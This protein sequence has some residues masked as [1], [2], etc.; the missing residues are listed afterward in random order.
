MKTDAM[1]DWP[2]PNGPTQAPKTSPHRGL[3]WALSLSVAVHL[4]LVTLRFAAPETYNRVFQ[5]TPLEVMLVNARSEEAP[6]KAQALAQVRLAGGGEVPQ[7]RIASSP[8]PPALNPDPGTDISAMQRQIEALKM[9]Q[10]RLLTQLKE[11]LSV[12]TRENAGD[13][14]DGPDRL[15]REQ[16]QQQLARQ[17]AQIEQRVDQI[18]GSAR[19]RYISPATQEVAY[20]LYYDKLRRTIE[21]Q[22]TLNFPEANGQ[23]IYGQLTMVITV[24]SRG[25]L[26]STEVAKPSGT[27]ML[28]ER[29]VVIVR[30]AAPFGVFTTKMRQQADQI[31]VVTRFDFSRDNTLETRMQAQ[32]NAKP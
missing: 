31:V 23:K 30:S 24:D 3:I 4:G 13:N 29:A 9:Q 27:P 15:A 6:Q 8:L 11:E 18:Q 22:G 28:D 10:M 14:K 2:N 12:L 5:D 7:V 25:K 32:E 16:R 17:L 26:L 1:A 19:K 20:A 21:Y